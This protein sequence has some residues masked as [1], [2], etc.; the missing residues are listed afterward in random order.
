[1]M[2]NTFTICFGSNI[3]N[4]N[5]IIETALVR[6]T[7]RITVSAKSEQYVSPSFNG[8]GRDYCNMVIIGSTD[9]ELMDLIEFTKLIE[10]ELGRTK[11]SK[12]LG[13]VPIDID[14]VSW[15]S[16]IIRPIDAVRPYYVYGLQNCK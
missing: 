3:D 6:I 10:I 13:I 16:E 12:L 11:Q 15:N 1:M 7:E 8:V 9:L 2:P 4:A 5:Q 14:V